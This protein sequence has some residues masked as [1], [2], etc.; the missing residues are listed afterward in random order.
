MDKFSRLKCELET[1]IDSI[2]LKEE[3]FE[4]FKLI[5]REFESNFM[6]IVVIGNFN[7][8]KTTSLQ[9]LHM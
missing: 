1:A 2:K 8:G 3:L 4:Y 6:N 7:A 9:S 5:C